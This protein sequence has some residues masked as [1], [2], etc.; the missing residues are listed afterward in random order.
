[1]GLAGRSTALLKKFAVAVHLATLRFAFATLRPAALGQART[2][3]P[4]YVAVRF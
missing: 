3:T 1:L 2:P 4:L